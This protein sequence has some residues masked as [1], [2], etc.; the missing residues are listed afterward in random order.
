MKVQLKLSLHTGPPTQP[1][2]YV[3]LLIRSIYNKL[4]NRKFASE[5]SLLFAAYYIR[6][7]HNIAA[8][9]RLHVHCACASTYQST[10]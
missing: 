7:L 2:K 8:A 10:V 3:L 5:L 9:E 4:F 6:L 1:V